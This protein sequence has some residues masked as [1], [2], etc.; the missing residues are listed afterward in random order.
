MKPNTTHA[1]VLSSLAPANPQNEKR[2][3]HLIVMPRALVQNGDDGS[4]QQFAPLEEL[5]KGR[6]FGQEIV[7][8]CVRWYLSFKLSY[9]DLVAMMA[10]RGIDLAHT[11]ILR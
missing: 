2:R 11:T 4:M 10:E 8:L 7:V 5:F 6:H 3:L 1:T 9:R